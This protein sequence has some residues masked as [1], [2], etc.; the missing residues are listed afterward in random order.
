[1]PNKPLKVGITGGIGSG[2][3]I[4]SKMFSLLGAP[5]YNADLRAR[6]LMENDIE[7]VA[8][9]KSGFGESSYK[10]GVVNRDYLAKEVFSNKNKLEQLNH[11][12]HPAVSRDFEHWLSLRSKSSYVLK[13]AALLIESGSYKSLDV[14]IAVSCPFELRVKRVLER[15]PFR[16]R[17]EVS[18]IIENQITDKER[19]ALADIIIFN[20]EE[21][22][23]IDQ[24]L[25]LH[26]KFS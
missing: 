2:K 8:Q 22:S 16:S 12:V 1:M 23:L 25:N 4:V 3:S 15:D 11:L 6:W 7:L 5:V 20:D 19:E 9:I 26:L 18:Q 10:N 14:L 21:N 13:E 24:V 17:N